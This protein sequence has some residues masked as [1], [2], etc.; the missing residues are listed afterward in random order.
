MAQAKDCKVEMV[1]FSSGVLAFVTADTPAKLDAFE[2][3]YAAL[4]SAQTTAH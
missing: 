1:S 3:Q 4:A 2:K